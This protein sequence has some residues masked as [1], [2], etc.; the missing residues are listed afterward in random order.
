[1]YKAYYSILIR[2]LAKF[3]AEVYPI[4]EV[5][6]TSLIKFIRLGMNLKISLN[7]P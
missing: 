5:I 4:S 6:S 7:I 2:L 1:M 3:L